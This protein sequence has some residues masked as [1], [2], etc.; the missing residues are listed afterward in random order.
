MNCFTP[1]STVLQRTNDRSSQTLWQRTCIIWLVVWFD[2][3]EARITQ[4]AIGMEVIVTINRAR[5][6]RAIF[7]HTIMT[8]NLKWAIANWGLLSL[9][10]F[11]IEEHEAMLICC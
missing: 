1:E 2:D 11:L 8:T 3:R 9:I 4:L 7:T 6:C 5:R 10:R